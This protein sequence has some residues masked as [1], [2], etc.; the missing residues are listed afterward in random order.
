MELIIQVRGECICFQS[1]FFIKWPLQFHLKC[2]S[3]TYNQSANLFKLRNTYS[4]NNIEYSCELKTKLQGPGL[5]GVF[6]CKCEQTQT[7]QAQYNEFGREAGLRTGP[8]RGLRQRSGRIVGEQD[9]QRRSWRGGSKS[10]LGPRPRMSSSS[11]LLIL[12]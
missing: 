6:H 12:H 7:Q 10:V 11:P 3:M 2:E 1:I 8:L 5:E 9:H 4:F